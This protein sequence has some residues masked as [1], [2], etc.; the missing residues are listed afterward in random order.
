MPDTLTHPQ[1]ARIVAVTQLVLQV[2]DDLAARPPS[3]L[4]AAEADLWACLI[5]SRDDLAGIRQRAHREMGLPA[6]AIIRAN[7]E[8][9]MES[10]DG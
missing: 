9:M 4:S 7:C 6:V 10:K 3:S 2:L 5:E 8:H 1:P